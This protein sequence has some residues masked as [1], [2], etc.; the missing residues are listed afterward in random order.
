MR[1]P[2]R[3]RLIDVRMTIFPFLLTNTAAAL[4]KTDFAPELISML[5]IK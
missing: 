4:D 2:A 3:D 5:P 1:S